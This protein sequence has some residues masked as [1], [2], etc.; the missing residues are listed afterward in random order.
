MTDNN[1]TFG[2]RF[3]L[4]RKSIARITQY[5]G[6]ASIWEYQ[7]FANLQ[8]CSFF[9]IIIVFAG[10][11]VLVEDENLAF[12][13]AGSAYLLHFLQGYI[14]WLPLHLRRLHDEGE[15][16]F[17]ARIIP[18]ALFVFCS[19]G[20]I[21]LFIQNAEMKIPSDGPNQHGPVEPET[22]EFGREIRKPEVSPKQWVYIVIFLIIFNIIWGIIKANM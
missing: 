9:M 3:A 18:N 17:P 4:Y 22:L 15:E 13:F 19:L 14:I 12:I 2:Q 11:I 1:P 16:K 20:F 10:L 8:I 21:G 6:R 5:S 7:A